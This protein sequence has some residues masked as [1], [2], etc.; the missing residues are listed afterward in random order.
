M[1][2]TPQ[3]CKPITVGPY[4]CPTLPNYM[5]GNGILT[6]VFRDLARTVVSDLKCRIKFATI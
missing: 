2:G 6:C 3:Q 5:H 4:T 1:A